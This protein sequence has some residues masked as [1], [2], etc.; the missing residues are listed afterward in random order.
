MIK[1]TYKSKNRNKTREKQALLVE[2]AKTET[3]VQTVLNA[4]QASLAAAEKGLPI[5]WF[6]SFFGKT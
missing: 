1:Q 2:Q 6:T 4:S 3:L 5:A